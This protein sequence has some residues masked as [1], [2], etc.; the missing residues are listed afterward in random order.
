V[1]IVQSVNSKVITSLALMETSVLSKDYLSTFLPFIATLSVKMNY[2]IIEISTVVNDFKNEFGI[3]IPRAPMQSIL[4]RAVNKGLIAVTKDGRYVPNIDEMNNNS[5]IHKKDLSDKSIDVVIEQ[6]LSFSRIFGEKHN[7]DISR[8]E[9]IDI[10]IGFLDRYSPKTIA[11]NTDDI[12]RGDSI[13]KRNLFLMGRF[14]Q[15]VSATNVP[16][17]DTIQK[18]AMSHLVSV[19]LAFDLPTADGA[20]EFEEIVIYL[21][22]PIVLRLLGLQTQEFEDSYREMFSTFTETIR[23]KYM[24]YQHT[25][26]EITR[27]L[28]DCANW[29]ENSN[30]NPL[31]ANQALLSFVE[32]KFN[33][34]QIELY[35]EGLE[36]EL[37]ENAIK[38]DKSEFYV[39]NHRTAQID[40]NK[41]KERLID[42]YT[43]KNPNFDI[44][45][46]ESSISYDIQSIENTVKLWGSKSSAKYSA[47]G[48]IFLTSNSTLAYVC[49]RF[50]SE[51]WWDNNNHKSPCVTDY[52]LG[53]MIWLSTP[54]KKVENFSKL[55]L[56]S[57][58]N[59]ATILSRE[60]MDKFLYELK[61]LEESERVKNSAL[62][63][64]DAR[65]L[66]RDIFKMLR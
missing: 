21:D 37:S 36:D 19:A 45:R 22:T 4:S 47:L 29:I 49:R 6:F 46:N 51:Y 23:P 55:K 56:L 53:T 7:I 63:L 1:D 39:L 65:H 60:V 38:V 54:V 43:E 41:L 66:K 33:K 28:G 35:I 30:F 9:A 10:F 24:I 31:Y 25:F 5:F 26:D 20:K 11:G 32:R 64:L 15:N 27:I 57:D 61:R 14:I 17:F 13:S 40:Y 58:C 42:A 16:L 8:D 50:T 2:E 12:V 48:S 18:L 62:I 52:Y 44:S 3:N 59:S 34:T